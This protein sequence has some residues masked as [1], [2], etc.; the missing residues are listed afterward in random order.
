[1]VYVLALAGE[2][3]GGLTW[4]KGGEQR[5][6]APAVLTPAFLVRGE[7]GPAGKVARAVAAAGR[8]P[9]NIAGMDVI[10]VIERAYIPTTGRYHPTQLF[11]HTLAVEGLLRAGEPVPS[12][13]VNA[14]AARRASFPTAAWF[15]RSSSRA[16]STEQGSKRRLCD[17]AGASASRR[18][19]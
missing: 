6:D 5:A 12:A 16:R 14:A 9:H 11:H 15:W 2:D 13:A 4:T 3:P 1:M 19:S 18:S 8:D 10:D 17:R 7:A